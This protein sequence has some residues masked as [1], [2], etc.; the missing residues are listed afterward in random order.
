[1][2]F[3]I[4]AATRHV[5]IQVSDTRLTD[6]KNGRLV[7]D[8]S[9]K[10][11]LAHCRDAKLLL[12]FTGLATIRGKN[13]AKWVADRLEKFQC[14]NKVFSEVTIYI[15]EELSEAAKLDRNLRQYGVTID[16][17]GLGYS[18]G[19]E[20]QPAIAVVTNVGRP[21]SNRNRFDPLDPRT[22]DFEQYFMN[23]SREGTYIGISGSGTEGKQLAINGLRR[24]LQKHLAGFLE[25]EDPRL[26]L[27]RFVTMLK[28]HRQHPVLSKFIGGYC[29]ATAIKSDFS[30]MIVSHGRPGGGLLLPI[31]VGP[32]KG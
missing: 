22:H 30:S 5:A 8:Y 4:S 16:I 10:M 14:W 11:I 21:S 17:V 9:V 32:P 7:N 2:T 6:A 20:R 1:M 15:R 31:V 25:G 27:T 23:L 26:I 18:P 19:G 3:I 28:L 24:K 12:S 29:V 13:L